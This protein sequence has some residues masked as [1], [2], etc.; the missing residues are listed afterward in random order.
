MGEHGGYV[1][2]N[3]VHILWQLMIV[4]YPFITGLVAGA[5]ILSSLYYVF[6][7]NKLKPIARLSLVVSLGFLLFTPITLLLHIGHPERCFNIFLTPNLDSAMAAFGFIYAGYMA[8]LVFE[9][10]LVHREEIIT[11]ARGSQGLRRLFYKCLALGVYD[12]SEEAK[13]VDRRAVVVLAALGYRE[14]RCCTG[15]WVS[16]SVPS[17]PTPGGPHP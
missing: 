15:T 4:M 3:D 1:F 16:S 11:L 7:R 8:L 13:Q 12:I 10:W 17:R 5:S 2:P 14:P 9:I 6:H